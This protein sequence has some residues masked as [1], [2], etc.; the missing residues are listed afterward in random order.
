MSTREKLMLALLAAVGTWFVFSRQK[1][2]QFVGK[3]YKPYSAKAKE[4]LRFAAVSAGLPKS[5]GDS[6]DL[7]YILQRESKGWVGIP[8]YTF[9]G[10]ASP[11]RS[12]EWP[13]IWARLQA[14][15][16][17]TK[18]TAT[19]LGQLLT[20]NV[21][22]YYPVGLKGIG[23]PVNEAVGFVKYIADRYGS[24]TVARSVYNKKGNY[25]HA[26][27]GKKKYKGFAEGY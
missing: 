14:G 19:G 16:V 4:L 10:V 26:I 25:I 9:G 17:W 7:H 11:S 6:D 15:E 24:P 3:H 23:D 20:S 1:A 22:K 2:S 27:T 18:S 21:K 12:G 8:N 5:W 13:K